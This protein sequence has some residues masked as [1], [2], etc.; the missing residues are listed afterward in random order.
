MTE[1]TMPN[2]R[3]LKIA[4]IVMGV[5]LLIG[6]GAVIVTLIYQAKHPKVEAAVPPRAL[7]AALAPGG[8]VD[9]V[10]LD[11]NRLAVGLHDRDGRRIV[12]FDLAKGRATAVIRLGGTP[13][14]ARPTAP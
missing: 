4:V 11:G 6:F 13:D 9:H 1:Q 8:A 2:T 12:V 3:A 14:A 10:A 5:L 7:A